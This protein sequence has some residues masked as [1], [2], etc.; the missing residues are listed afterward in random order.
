MHLRTRGIGALVGRTG[1][2]H[3]RMPDTLEPK[4]ASLGVR[5]AVVRC[6]SV[7]PHV[8]D[9][10]HLLVLEQ[11]LQRRAPEKDIG[12]FHDQRMRPRVEH[13]SRCGQVLSRCVNIS[14]SAL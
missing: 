5:H 2:I 10:A 4:D 3:F 12:A 13:I 14:A 11:R 1:N 7:A 6:R 8:Q 9:Q